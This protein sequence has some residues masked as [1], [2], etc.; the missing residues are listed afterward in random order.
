MTTS[1]PNTAAS[2]GFVL[3]AAVIFIATSCSSGGKTRTTDDAVGE[4]RS[5]GSATVIDASSNAFALGIPTLDRAERRAFAVGN[6]FFNDNWVTA[7]ASTEARDGLGP[8]F[9]AQ[10]CSTCHF[11]DGRAQPPQSD[12]D[13]RR[14]LLFRL[15]VPGPQGADAPDPVY[16]GQLQDRSIHGVPAEATVRITTREVPGRF[17]DG[18]RYTLL[19]PSYEIVDPA[20]GPPARDV[21]VS[22]R[23][24]PAVFG[25][26]LLES[27]PEDEIVGHADPDDENGDGISGRPNRVR[28]VKTD[29]L[30]LGRFGW[31]AN[32]PSVEQQNAGA[33]NGD[34][35]ITSSVFPDTLCTESQHACNEAPDGG[36]PE[37]DDHRLGRVT[38]YTR[39]LAVPARRDVDD[40]D[41]R[42]GE[43]L[44]RAAACSSC[45]LPT[46]HTGDSDIDALAGQTIHPF[47][48]L[49]LHDMGPGLAD[50][51]PD[52]QASGSEWRTA[53]LWGIGL[54]ETVN[55]HTRFLHDGRA[56][57]LTE[58]ILWHG[59]EAEAAK[60]RFRRMSR[61]DRDALITYLE[62]L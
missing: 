52:G 9:N 38:F 60:E 43:Q 44:F 30:V 28:A 27:V 55:R 53:P 11:H 26:G 62:S 48:D 32:V 20:Y 54:V 29:R 40:V 57:N 1:R 10:S 45:H 36:E 46:L 13:P 17:A 6:S 24:A 16:G 33:F 19:A 56:R 15:S 58:A 21:M 42:K 59:G 61:D 8:L 31:K 50:R 14:G 37:I 22:P 51:R 5:G 39:T 25:V 35:G 18:T 4:A 41:V 34:I 7:P 2:R 3:A 49:L 12:D 47:T 23:I